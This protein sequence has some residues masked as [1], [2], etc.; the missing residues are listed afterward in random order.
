[1]FIASEKNNEGRDLERDH[2]VSRL[3]SLFLARN[4]VKGERDLER[5]IQRSRSRHSE[6]MPHGCHV[7]DDIL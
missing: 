4:L 6:S 7:A 5:R 1:M 3:A 2:N